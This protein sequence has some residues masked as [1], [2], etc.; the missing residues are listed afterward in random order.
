MM[1][2]GGSRGIANGL[3]GFMRS[4]GLSNFRALLSACQEC[5]HDSQEGVLWLMELSGRL[6]GT[7][8]PEI[9]IPLTLEHKT[10]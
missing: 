3:E 9:T 7:L 2:A 6:K 5:V 10:A 4:E 8:Y 1:C